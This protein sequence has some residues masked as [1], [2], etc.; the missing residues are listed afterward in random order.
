MEKNAESTEKA[1]INLFFV[2]KWP[3]QVATCLHFAGCFPLILRRLLAAA[4]EGVLAKRRAGIAEET[5]QGNSLLCV[6]YYMGGPVIA[7]DWV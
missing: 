6:F 3:L 1:G 5:I 4:S 2:L 7:Q